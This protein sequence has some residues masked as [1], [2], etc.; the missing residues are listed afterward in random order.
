MEA[1]ELQYRYNGL[2]TPHVADALL[3]LGVPVRSAPADVRPL[4]HGTRLIGPARPARHYGSVDVFLE[5]FERARPG[6]VLVVDNAGRDDEACVGDLAALEA[7]QAGL[8]GIVIWGLHRDTRDLHAIRL[9]VFSQGAV[10]AG[11]QRLDPQEPEALTAARFGPHLVTEADFVLGDDDG[12]LFLPLDR[13]ADIAEAAAS[14][15]DVEH[16]QATLM[17][18]GTSL[19]EQVRFAEYLASRERDGTTFRGHLRAIGGA[20]EE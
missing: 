14:I 13:A 17:G 11:P 7:R 6:D 18:L 3:R 19:R 20:I 2:T 8:A 12:V 15:R 4:W 9:P 16:R 5:A 1:L 10:P